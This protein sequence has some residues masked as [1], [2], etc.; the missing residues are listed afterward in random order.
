LLGF[1]CHW[2]FHPK[3]VKGPPRAAACAYV[4]VVVATLQIATRLWDD[5]GLGLICFFHICLLLA[6]ACY[7]GFEQRGVKLLQVT[8][9]AVC[10]GGIEQ[11]GGKG[12]PIV[13]AI[14]CGSVALLVLALELYIRCFDIGYAKPKLDIFNYR[15]LDIGSGVSPALPLLFILSAWIWWC[16]QTLTGVASTIEKHIVMPEADDFDLEAG[17]ERKEPGRPLPEDQLSLRCVLGWAGRCFRML[18]ATTPNEHTYPSAPGTRPKRNEEIHQPAYDSANPAAASRGVKVEKSPVEKFDPKVNPEVKVLVDAR[19]RI[20]LKALAAG[21]NKSL[22]DRTGPVPFGWDETIVWFALA[23]FVVIC[24][25][26]SPS[27][28]AEAFES[29]AYKWIYWILLYTCLLLICFLVTHIVSLWTDLRGLLLSIDRLR[30]CR[31]FADLKSLTEKPLW[32][33]ASSGRQEF[34]QVLSSEIDA[35]PGANN[36]SMQDA[37][38]QGRLP[39]AIDDAKNAMESLSRKYELLVNGSPVDAASI[40]GAF[41]DLQEKLAKTASAALIF[42]N[43]GWK[44][45]DDELL[46]KRD[47]AKESDA[48]NAL[49]EPQATDPVLRSIDRFLYLFYLNIVLAPLR[50]LQTLILALAGVFVFVLMSYSSYPFESRESFHVLLISIFCIISVVVGVVYGQMYSN[51]FL[52]RVTSAKPGQLG[53]DFWIRFGTFVFVALLSLLSVQFP[54]INSFLFSWLKPALESVK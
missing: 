4:A 31:A 48:S 53:V 39:K 28:I 38:D 17:A 15:Y 10:D 20:R 19:D 27:E 23:E 30:F 26:M 52:R 1:A 51:A 45:E 46:R 43:A 25:L 54:G 50:R 3:E 11:R 35:L 12:L 21:S 40:R 49:I 41:H 44:R 32:K 13:G 47:G 34:I 22:N 37:K 14:A 9:G 36:K 2:G 29:P 6:L 24:V 42:S 5:M 7:G 18:F 8:R 33:L 16:W